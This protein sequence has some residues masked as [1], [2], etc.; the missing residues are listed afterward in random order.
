[1][2]R[3]GRAGANGV[4]ISF[5]CPDEIEYLRD[6]QKLL[7]RTIPILPTPDLPAPPPVADSPGGHHRHTSRPA[8]KNAAPKKGA[9]KS[10]HRKP[11]PRKAHG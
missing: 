6:I 7:K 3:T 10:R 11:A 4:A 8:A 1:I 9:N 5:C 2:G